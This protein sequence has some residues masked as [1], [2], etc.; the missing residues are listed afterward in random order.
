MSLVD[1]HVSI[2]F[3]PRQPVDANRERVEALLRGHHV[4]RAFIHHL[5]GLWYDPLWSNDQLLKTYDGDHGEGPIY[6]CVCTVNPLEGIERCREVLE[7]AFKQGAGYWRLYPVEQGWDVVHPVAL[8]LYEYLREHKCGLLLDSGTADVARVNDFTKDELPMVSSL[9][10]YDY[11]DWSIRFRDSKSLY[12]TT[13]LLHGPGSVEQ[14][15]QSFPDRLLFASNT[16]FGSIQSVL[17]LA[18]E[19]ILEVDYL[20]LLAKNAIALM[21]RVTHGG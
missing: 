11:A 1:W 3:S 4:G 13:R 14:A 16:P 17:N 6:T 19:H 5:G 8:Y 15:I 12:P 18:P 2:G 9:H 20:D 21:E 7:T 10:F